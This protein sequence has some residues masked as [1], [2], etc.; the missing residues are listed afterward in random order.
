[1]QLY[2]CITNHTIYC[3]VYK[4][5]VNGNIIDIKIAVLYG[6][7]IFKILISRAMKVNQVEFVI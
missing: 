5:T 6:H 4:T 1:M 7:I 3:V 2:M